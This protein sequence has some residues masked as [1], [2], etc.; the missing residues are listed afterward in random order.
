METIKQEALEK[1][2]TNKPL[3][4]YDS[5]RI[6]FQTW[7]AFIPMVD[8][9]NKL[10]DVDPRSYDHITPYEFQKA[11]KENRIWVLW[12]LN[13]PAIYNWKAPHSDTNILEYYITE[14]SY[15]SKINIRVNDLPFINYDNN[16]N[17]LTTDQSC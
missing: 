11:M 2:L 5:L 10:I 4:K 7:E 6:S 15:P 8:E 13:N 3:T 17:H 9:N 14:F 12:D 16:P 1:H